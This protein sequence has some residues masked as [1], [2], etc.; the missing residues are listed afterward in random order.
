[1]T[2]INEYKNR[3]G[4]VTAGSDSGFIF[5]LYGFAYIR[6]LELLREAGFHPIEVIMAATL[7]GAEA[8]GM[9]DQIG[10]IEV[11][12][13]ADILIIEENP[14]ENLKVLYGT[15]AIKL[16]DENE[17][18]RVGGVKYTIKDGIVFDSKLLLDDVKKMVRKS[19]DDMKYE[20]YQPGQKK[21]FKK[22]NTR[23]ID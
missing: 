9:D 3:G 23:K 21:D 1:M 16:N 8:L 11:G 12:K 4:R 14:L 19:K 5:Q 7:N 6:E 22:E 18:T 13:K 15:G 20:I 2:F 17:V 10:S